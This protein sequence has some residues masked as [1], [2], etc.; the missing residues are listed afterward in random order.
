MGKYDP[1]AERLGRARD[2]EV[3]LSF[4][5]IE[6]VIGAELPKGAREKRGWWA[7]SDGAHAAAWTSAGF[8]VEEVDLDSESVTYKRAKAAKGANGSGGHGAANDDADGLAG[9]F[10]HGQQQVQELIETGLEQAGELLRQAAPTFRRYG[11]Y[12]LLGVA[13][14]AIAGFF[15]LRQQDQD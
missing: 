13:A 12:L 14:A 2:K 7:D 4:A 15:A 10:A 1:L 3:R 9:R 11:P 5:E 6:Q 8:K